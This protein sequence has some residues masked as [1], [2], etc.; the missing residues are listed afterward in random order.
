MNRWDS[1]VADILAGSCDARDR[2][3]IFL[4][5]R[6]ISSMVFIATFLVIGGPASAQTPQEIVD[7]LYPENRLGP[8]DPARRESCFAVQTVLSGTPQII[9][10][11]YTDQENGVIQ[12]IA[13]SSSG[14]YNVAYQLPDTY[15]L[16]GFNCDAELVDVDFDT[17]Q[18]VL[19]TFLEFGHEIGWLLKWTG[20]QLLN[21]TP[22][23]HAGT[24]ELS[25]FYD[26]PIPIDLLHTGWLQVL[27]PYD[28]K[29]TDPGR[30]M[31]F[32]GEFYQ[33]FA[34]NY[35]LSQYFLE[36]FHVKVNSPDSDKTRY[37]RQSEDSRGPFV[38]K[39]VNGDRFGLHRATGGSIT[40]NG[41]VVVDSSQLTTATEFLEVPLATLPVENT[42][43]VTL[44]GDPDATVIITVQ[45]G[46]AR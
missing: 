42:L 37:F 30:R 1:S 2:I 21:L 29:T 44:S 35:Q 46:T 9:V 41:T 3:K 5:M 23:H 31:R 18:E 19:I 38:L 36:V 45:D 15:D 33:A 16:S 14:R 39:V 4:K 40:L 27:C 6:F 13:R 8:V 32:P 34:G 26:T 25:S 12:V 43:S 22:T 28:F 7:S 10:A 11:G 20:S 24:L 17:H